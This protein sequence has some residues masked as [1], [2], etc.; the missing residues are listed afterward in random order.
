VHISRQS[1]AAPFGRATRLANACRL[2]PGRS[3]PDRIERQI[4]VM[5]A[6]G[7]VG[8][9]AAAVAIIAEV[10]YPTTLQQITTDFERHRQGAELAQDDAT[11]CLAL[12]SDGSP[13]RWMANGLAS[14]RRR[15][16]RGRERS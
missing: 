9:F 8:E 12:S 16:S 15:H 2:R 1:D 3:K 10:G 14:A 13:I 5:E 6:M 7:A 11:R 4:A